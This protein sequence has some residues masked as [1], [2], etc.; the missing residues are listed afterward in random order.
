MSIHDHS[1]FLEVQ[2]QF[3]IPYKDARGVTR[4]RK[5]SNRELTNLLAAIERGRARDEEIAADLDIPL[6]TVT[7]VYGLW[8][9]TYDPK[10]KAKE[11]LSQRLLRE[12]E[13]EWEAQA[14]EQL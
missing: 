11:T 7:Q 2:R 4:L 6:A 14:D 3:T 1:F 12:A 10:P 5:L 8:I 9:D 13:E